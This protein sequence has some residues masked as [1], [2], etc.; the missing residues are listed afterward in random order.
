MTVSV[1]TGY[2]YGLFSVGAYNF[3]QRFFYSLGNYKIPFFV[4]IFVA[5]LDIGLSLWLKET[6]L[7]VAGLSIANSISFTLGLVFLLL[8]AKKIT[9]SLQIRRI[10][11]T[12]G[13]I[14]LTLV[15]VYLFNHFFLKYTGEWWIRGSTLPNLGRLLVFICVD[16]GIIL[17]SYRIFRI[18]M[19]SILFQFFKRKGS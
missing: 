13:K 11:V 8:A 7:R 18:E 16:I 14:I 5:V 2:C 15:P 19:V 4:S 17:G 9:G 3:T 6:P 10:L 1:L 12:L